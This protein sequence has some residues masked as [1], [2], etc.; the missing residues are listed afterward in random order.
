MWFAANVHDGAWLTVRNQAA[1]SAYQQIPHCTYPVLTETPTSLKLGIYHTVLQPSI[2]KP[3]YRS[4][5]SSEQKATSQ[6]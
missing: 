5:D 4:I 3:P 1:N 2:G 6:H